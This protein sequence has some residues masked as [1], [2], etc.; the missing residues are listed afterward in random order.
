[1]QSLKLSLSV[2]IE[3]IFAELPVEMR[4]EAVKAEGLNA[5][6][7][8]RWS[9]KDLHSIRTKADALDMQIAAIVAETD[10]ALVD[11][12][13]HERVVRGL[14]ASIDTA[15]NLNCHTVIVTTGNELA[16]VPRQSQHESI[17][18]ALTAVAPHAE[19]KNVVMVLEPL[20]TLVDHRGYYLASSSEGFEIVR[21]VNSRCVRLLYDVYHMQIMEGNL[22]AT[23]TANIDL[24][25]HFHIADV[26]G[27]HEPGTGEI[28][29]VNVLRA[30]AQSGYTG[31]IGL[32]FRPSTSSADA[33]QRT[34]QIANEAIERW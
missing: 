8:W 23:I 9:D 30:I 10:G 25:G 5:F 13:A 7:F 21:E 31:F 29:Y 34:I 11:P 12:N 1:M 15:V 3:M 4:M 20:N 24:I 18:K 22:I 33:L 27:R 6:E 26:P 19:E 14:C 17:V 28:N 2:C 32:E 16:G